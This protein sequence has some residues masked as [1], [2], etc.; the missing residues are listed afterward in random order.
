MPH[1]L[2]IKPDGQTHT[3]DLPTDVLLRLK[4]MYALIG[5]RCMAVQLVTLSDQFDMW[6]DEEGL[7]TQPPNPKATLLAQRFGL[8]WD[9]YHGPAIITGPEVSSGIAV[10]ADEQ[11]AHLRDLMANS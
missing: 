11:I 8:T 10:L 4:T 9:T 6:V 7:C 5:N 2:V 1:A 3:E